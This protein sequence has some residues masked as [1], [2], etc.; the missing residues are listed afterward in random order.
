MYSTSAIMTFL[1]FVVLSTITAFFI[2]YY[3]PKGRAEAKINTG[4]AFFTLLIA[5]WSF[6]L[7][8]I[9]A[10]YAHSRQ[11]ELM[12]PGEAVPE[13]PSNF[14]I[15]RGL[16]PFPSDHIVLPLEW[17]N[18]GGQPIIVK[19]PTL[20]LH[21]IAG[22]KPLDKYTFSLAGAFPN[23]YLK[24]LKEENYMLTK[25]FSLNPHSIIQKVL[26]FHV[27]Y[28]WDDVSEEHRQYYHFNF[29]SGEKYKVDLCFQMGINDEEKCH[30]ELFKLEF[31]ESV[32][33]LDRKTNHWIDEW[34]L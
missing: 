9:N 29:K 12:K 7:S 14:I 33:F 25:S 11:E 34:T 6:S 4:I 8:G 10:Y 27:E 30:K 28:W 22:Q 23:T 5:F 13:K 32:D 2:V 26:V 3:W 16:D 24:S 18:L 19:H 17:S 31:Y 20:V 1:F 15:I 21:K